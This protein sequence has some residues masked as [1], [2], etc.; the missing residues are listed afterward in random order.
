MLSAEGIPRRLTGSRRYSY[1]SNE[2]IFNA[3]SD[4]GASDVSEAK[5]AE[6]VGTVAG[7]RGVCLNDE[8]MLV[9]EWGISSW[10]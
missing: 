1:S 8:C 2:G 6:E 9:G 5:P 7:A 4:D 3:G 10:E